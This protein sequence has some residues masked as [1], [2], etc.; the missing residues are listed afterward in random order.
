MASRI[1]NVGNTKNSV[2]FNLNLVA[3]NLEGVV[4]CQIIITALIERCIDK[5]IRKRLLI[6]Y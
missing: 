5:F 4:L 1:F 2:G 3:R 6:F